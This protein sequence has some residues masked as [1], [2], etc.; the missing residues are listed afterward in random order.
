MTAQNWQRIGII[1]LGSN[2]SRLIVMAY[3]PG[4]AFRLIDEVSAAVRL[5]EGIGRDRRLRAGPI[6]R[7]VEALAMFSDLCEATGVEKVV[8]VGTSAIREA[9]NQHEFWAALRAATTLDL[10][11]ISTDDEA[12]FGYLGAINALPITDG[13]TF[14]TG[15][16]STQV[17]EVRGRRRVHSASAQAGVLRFSEKYIKSDPVNRTDLRKLRS[18]ASEVFTPLE[19]LTAQPG[20]RLG[21]VGGTVRQLARIDQ[22]QRNYPLDRVHGYALRREAIEQIIEELARRDRRGRL[23]LPG[24][25]A[26]RVDVTLAGAV[27]IAELMQHVGLSELLVSGQGVREGLFY[28]HFIGGNPA[29]CLDQR[30]FSVSNIARLTHYEAG[31]SEQV[32]VLAL[33]LF[34][35]LQVL[36]GYGAWERD[37]LGHAATLHDIGISV[38][39][40]DHHK[41]GE[42]LIYNSTLLGFSHRETVIIASL[43]RNHRKGSSGAGAYATILAAGDEQRIELLSGLLR[44][45]EYLERGKSRRV[46][47]LHVTLGERIVIDVSSDH[48]AELEIWEAGRRSNLL[49]RCLGREIVIQAAAAPML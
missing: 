21:G 6:R 36:H 18:A 27:I 20:D 7:A 8:A 24:L 11:I 37:L 10:Q 29:L 41:H 26:D 17:V 46:T 19:W 5:A 28:Q 44:V 22:K 42:Y 35:Q 48:G 9:A 38:G 47:A 12:Y 49:A 45:A 39:Y 25:K 16:G 40:Y 14:D 33:S 15:G 43:V 30:S 2:T 13:F 23:Q 32:R 34:D 1:D 4:Y 31:H 3:I